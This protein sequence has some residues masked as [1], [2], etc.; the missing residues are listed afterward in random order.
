MKYE[1]HKKNKQNVVNLIF[2]VIFFRTQY[3]L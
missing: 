3:N 1:V 2:N